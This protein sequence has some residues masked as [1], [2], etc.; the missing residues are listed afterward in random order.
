MSRG[1]VV[2]AAVKLYAK[3]RELSD[4]CIKEREA[5]KLEAL[6]PTVSQETLAYIRFMRDVM[7]PGELIDSAI[8]LYRKLTES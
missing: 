4:E 5:T 7:T 6:D 3:N 2:D 1:Q 8:M